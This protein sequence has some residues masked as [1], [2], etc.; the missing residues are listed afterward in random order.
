LIRLERLA[1][2]HLVNFRVAIASE[3]LLGAAS[4]ADVEIAVGVVEP[5]PGETKVTS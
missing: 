1:V 3:V 5:A 2:D 4:V